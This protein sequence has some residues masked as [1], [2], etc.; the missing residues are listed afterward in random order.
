MRIVGIDLGEKRIG[1]AISDA[2]ATI[3]RPLTT[4]ERGRSDVEA[5]K[6]LRDTIASLSDEDRIGRI[7]VGLP[8]RLNGSDNDQTPRVKKIAELLAAEVSI[9]VVTQDER[10]SSR[11]AEE[12]LSLREKDWRKRK[13][14]L[15]AAAAAVILQDYLDSAKQDE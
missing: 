7:V 5:V 8:T 3:A 11:E 13:A 14:K 15:D 2:T 9:P 6:L 1:I 4:L 10:L 12:R